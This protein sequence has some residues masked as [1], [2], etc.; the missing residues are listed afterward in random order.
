MEEIDSLDLKPL[1][2]A[3]RQ[4]Q[5]RGDVSFYTDTTLQI[6]VVAWKRLNLSSYLVQNGC[7]CISFQTIGH[8]ALRLQ[9]LRPKSQDRSFRAAN[10]MAKI[11][12]ETI[13]QF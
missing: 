5:L 6:V 11:E 8:C 1:P 9:P 7:Y 12:E 10:K 2:C 3:G 13:S 4:N